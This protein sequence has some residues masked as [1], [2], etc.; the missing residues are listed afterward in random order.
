MSEVY[1]TAVLIVM[2]DKEFA[3]SAVAKIFSYTD[4]IV[5][6]DAIFLKKVYDLASDIFVGSH[7]RPPPAVLAA[8]SSG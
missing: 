6:A 5:C 7:V 1:R 8:A 4:K 2:L 3:R